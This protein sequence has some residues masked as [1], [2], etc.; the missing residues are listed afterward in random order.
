M[1]KR[2]YIQIPYAV[3]SRLLLP[4]KGIG[5]YRVNKDSPGPNG[6]VEFVVYTNEHSELDGGATYMLHLGRQLI[7]QQD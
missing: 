1:I 6:N 5:F 4:G 2:S 3:L 7:K